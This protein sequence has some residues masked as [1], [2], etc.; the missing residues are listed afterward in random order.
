MDR[1]LE[2]VRVRAY[3]LFEQRGREN[4]HALDDWLTAEH[5]LGVVCVDDVEE[6]DK[7]FRVHVVCAD[8]T[9]DELVVYAEPKAISVEGKSAPKKLNTAESAVRDRALFGRCGLP[10]A[11]DPENVKAWLEDGVLEIVAQKIIA[12]KPV[13]TRS[14]VSSSKRK[15]KR[16]KL[17]A[18]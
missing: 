3:E 5:E 12:P 7:E 11:I 18:G 4:G 17:T 13:I 9:A 8:L 1:L 2:K 10:E 15:V 14:R 6:T 16:G